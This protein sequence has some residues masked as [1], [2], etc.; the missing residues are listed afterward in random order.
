MQN[1][2]TQ[3]IAPK[4]AAEK[5]VDEVKAK[6]SRPQKIPDWDYKTRFNVLNEKHKALGEKMDAQ[7]AKIAGKWKKL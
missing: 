7:K 5:N 2:T 3:K 1:L 4:R 6:V